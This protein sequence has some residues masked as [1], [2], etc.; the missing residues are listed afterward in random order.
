[1]NNDCDESAQTPL[2]ELSELLR[3]SYARR[4]QNRRSTN[5][6][7]NES[8]TTRH[9]LI[10]EHNLGNLGLRSVGIGNI[11]E[12]YSGFDPFTIEVTAIPQSLTTLCQ[13]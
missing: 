6:R 7:I 9:R 5:Q 13:G 2:Q 3:H 1:M 4:A 11:Y 12:I 8:A 10:D